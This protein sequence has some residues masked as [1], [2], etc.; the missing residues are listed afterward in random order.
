[1]SLVPT[2]WAFS[3]ALTSGWFGVCHRSS[4][5]PR[6]CPKVP[7]CLDMSLQWTPKMA[8]GHWRCFLKRKRRWRVGPRTH[9]HVDLCRATSPPMENR[10]RRTLVRAIGVQGAAFFDRFGRRAHSRGVNSG[11]H[12]CGDPLRNR[13]R[14]HLRGGCAGP[15]GARDPGGIGAA[16]VVQHARLAI[17]EPLLLPLDRDQGPV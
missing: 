1:M 14:F 2:R 13:W 16:F 9:L 6:R 4:M 17:P 11:P 8:K 12:R 3:G 15:A 5:P 7:T 10:R